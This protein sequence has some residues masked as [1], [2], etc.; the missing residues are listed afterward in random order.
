MAEL[1]LELFCEEIPARMQP[2]ACA[3][4]EHLMG[5]A[6]DEASLSFD[7]MKAYATP[8]RLALHVEGLP[9]AQDDVKEE[10]RGP[11]ADA[12]EKALEGFLRSTG[13]KREDLEERE[14]KKGTFLYAAIERKGRPTSDVLGEAIPDIIRHFPWPKSMRWGKASSSLSSLRWVR[15]LQSILCLLDGAVVPFQIDDIEA[16]D[17]TRGH[18]FM[19]PDAFKVT[20]FA[21]YQAKLKEAYVLL[22]AEER[23]EQIRKEAIALCLVNKVGLQS[24][25]NLVAEN[26]GLTEW[27]VVL[28]GEFDAA[29]LD[30]PAEVLSLTMAKNQK[31]FTLLGEGKKITNKF[32]CVANIE[33]SDG[34][35]TIIAGNEKVLSARLSDAKFFWDQDLKATLED[36]LPK[37]RDIVFHEKLGTL[38]D[39]VEHVAALGRILA[40]F[41][42][43]G[44]D[45]V[46]KAARLAKADLV[47]NMVGEFPEV[48][49][50]MGGYYARRE[51]LDEVI[52]QA[53]EDHYKPQGPSD[54]CPSNPTSVAVALA[55]K[56][57]SL[58]GF[59]SIDEKPTG[60]K[61]P[62][63]LRRAALGAIRLIVE[64]DIRL[65]L[66]LIF[67]HLF[68]TLRDR[69][70]KARI[71]GGVF[72][73]PEALNQK[74][75]RDLPLSQQSRELVDFF[76]DRLKVQQREKGVSH[77]LV[78][79][80]F[81]Q[82]RDGDFV[83]L[84]ARVSALKAFLETEDGANLLVGYR[85]A[86]NIVRIEEKKD[87]KTFGGAIKT[88]LLKEAPEKALNAKLADVREALTVALD[89]EDFEAA[90][91][92][93]A[94][95]RV[96]VDDFFND[97]T[98]NSDDPALRENR[99]NLLSEIRN[100]MHL[101]ADF[102]KIGIN[103]KAELKV[104]ATVD[105]T[106]TTGNDD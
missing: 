38:E 87:G 65:P 43:A 55:D 32:L 18:R 103:L 89:A 7:A 14:E 20:S 45:Q 44:V 84:L 39:K 58:L 73:Q 31:Y 19:A 25:E 37:L 33:A 9:L 16:S 62:F 91:R 100:V 52:A 51:G 27:P 13:L 46:E 54:D 50:I 29:F 98:V 67:E 69:G 99:L 12:P 6:L 8:R 95:L 74:L 5:K 1:L 61:D 11:R 85:R 3:D 71:S 42:K 30:V 94:S 35:R 93:L 92:A 21:D 41:C 106:L 26:A 22:D 48:Q 83:R 76:A 64:N 49:G 101:V 60:S 96:P 70:F 47:S 86:A 80:T 40:P 28:M 24:D 82:D 88:D 66:G 56:L 77:D 2:K 90:M 78:D 104:T 10:R 72:G 105:A 4:L 57:N 68:A 23:K 81:S 34:G 102:S 36:R 59:F 15:P 53:I 97:V 63:A 17:E 75:P 79:A